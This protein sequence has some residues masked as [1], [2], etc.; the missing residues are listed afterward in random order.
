MQKSDDNKLHR[1]NAFSDAYKPLAE[2]QRN[3]DKTQPN[4]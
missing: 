2:Q 1:K 4:N 3:V